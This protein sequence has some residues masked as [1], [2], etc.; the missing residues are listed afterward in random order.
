MKTPL[1][2]TLAI[3]AALAA[4]MTSGAQDKPQNPPSAESVAENAFNDGNGLMKQRKYKEALARYQE[5]LAKTPDSPGLLFNGGLAAFMSKDFSTAEKLWKGLAEL[6]PDDW[7]AQA[8]LV[9][10]YQALGDLKARDEHRRKLLDLRKSGKSEDLNKL[11]Y[12]CRE[13]FEAAGKK[14]MV[15]EH[16]ELKGE[17]ALRYVFSVL[18]ESGEGEA[19]RISLG[20]YE[21]TNRIAVELGSVK[22]GE[23]QF[24]LDGYY[25]ASHATYGFFTPEP[26][27]DEVRKIVIGILEK[28]NQPQSQSRINPSTKK[29]DQEKKP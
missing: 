27:Y 16:F 18:D 26:S 20:S 9:Q 23:R 28:K 8:K 21:T 24:H 29:P 5:G 3:V 22:K 15:F 12:Y 13:Q 1:R 7:Q 19:F 2:I 25:G 6:D 14:L 17:R 4:S 10:A 11:D